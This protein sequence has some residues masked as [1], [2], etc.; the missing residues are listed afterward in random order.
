MRD[1]IDDCGHEIDFPA[2]QAAAAKVDAP[3]PNQEV[4]PADAAGEDIAENLPIE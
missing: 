1:E 4:V 2:T 3:A